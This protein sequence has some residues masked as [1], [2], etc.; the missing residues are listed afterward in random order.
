MA[1]K[2]ENTIGWGDSYEITW[3]GQG[4]DNTIGWGKVYEDES[5]ADYWNYQMSDWNDENTLWNEI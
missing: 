3:W 2:Y 5:Y 4:I 1:L